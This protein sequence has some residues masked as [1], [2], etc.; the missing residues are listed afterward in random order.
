M[1]PLL[2]VTQWLWECTDEITMQPCNLQI[3]QTSVDDARKQQRDSIMLT[4]LKDYQNAWTYTQ[5]NGFTQ[6]PASI[7]P[8]QVNISG[9]DAAQFSPLM[10]DIDG[11]VNTAAYK[12]YAWVE[13]LFRVAE[14]ELSLTGVCLVARTA[15]NS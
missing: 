14:V 10:V 11:N 2:Q 13:E 12:L 5:W 8:L 7:Y 4:G 3:N 15:R 6:V 9:T 1:Y